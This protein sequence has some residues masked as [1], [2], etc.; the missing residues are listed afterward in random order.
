MTCHDHSDFDTMNI[1]D[2]IHTAVKHVTL[3]L[4]W[5]HR[6]LVDAGHALSELPETRKPIENATLPSGHQTFAD[7]LAEARTGDKSSK[8]R[9]LDNLVEA[10]RSLAKA[11]DSASSAFAKLPGGLAAADQAYVERLRKAYELG[12]A[13]LARVLAE[14]RMTKSQAEADRR[15]AQEAEAH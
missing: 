13:E 15:L 9:R 4:E 10:E 11:F 5:L 2:G 12:T 1:N 7:A 8:Q 6:A 14:I 3:Q